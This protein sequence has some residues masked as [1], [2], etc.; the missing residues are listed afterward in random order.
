VKRRFAF[1]A[2]VLFLPRWEAGT[3]FVKAD[4]GEKDETITGR[5]KEESIG[6]CVALV[7][8]SGEDATIA[9]RIWGLGSTCRAGC[10][11]G[12]CSCGCAASMWFL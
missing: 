3:V 5:G 11:C 2:F 7:T 6:L 1:F 4:D 8:Q 10:H 9:G 12:C